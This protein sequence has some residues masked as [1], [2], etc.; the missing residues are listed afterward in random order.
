MIDFDQ[1]WKM[2]QGSRL[3]SGWGVEMANRSLAA[4]QLRAFALAIPFV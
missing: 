4:F 1:E 3:G 2:G